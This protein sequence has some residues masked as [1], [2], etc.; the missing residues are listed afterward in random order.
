MIVLLSP[1]VFNWPAETPIAILLR[2]VLLAN[3]LK[4]IA[5]LDVPAGLPK[6]NLTPLIVISSV[7]VILP[8]I[9]WLPVNVLLPVVAKLP[10]NV[11]LTNEDV[12]TVVVLPLAFPTQ[13]YP[14]CKDAV[15]VD[16]ISA[17]PDTTNDFNIVTLPSV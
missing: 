4:P 13:T 12:A 2:P 17:L 8:V 6:P 9:V 16:W 10:V 3:A 15:N 14:S 1:V 11:E 7:V 5:I